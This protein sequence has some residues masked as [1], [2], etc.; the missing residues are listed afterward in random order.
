MAPEAAIFIFN[1]HVL[2][3]ETTKSQRAKVNVPES[4]VYC[5][6]SQVLT[7]ARNTYVHPGRLPADAAIATDITGFEVGG[8]S[9]GGSDCKSCGFPR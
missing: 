7:G 9:S 1:A 6:Q 4:V 8:Y 3:A 5:F 2:F